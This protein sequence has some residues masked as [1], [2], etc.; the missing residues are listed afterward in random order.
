MPGASLFDLPVRRQRKEEKT[1]RQEYLPALELTADV[2][3]LLPEYL[4]RFAELI[5]FGKPPLVFGKVRYF[6]G[7][8]EIFLFGKA[9]RRYKSEH[10]PRNKS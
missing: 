7:W 10:R 3:P 5:I 4:R 6:N 2:I 1:I 9:I 8:K